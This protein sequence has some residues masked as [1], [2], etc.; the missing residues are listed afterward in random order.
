M[1]SQEELD[2]AEAAQQRALAI[3]RATFGDTHPFIGQAESQL[4]NV[5]NLRGRKSEARDLYESALQVKR[6]TLPKL[7]FDLVPTLVELGKLQSQLGDYG[8]ARCHLEE[9]RQILRDGEISDKLIPEVEA[10]L[11]RLDEKET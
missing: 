6:E 9:A 3:F 11:K 2:E 1:A 7:H 4:G 5:A 10:E 8:A